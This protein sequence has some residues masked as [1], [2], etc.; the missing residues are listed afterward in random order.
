M[1]QLHCPLAGRDHKYESEDNENAYENDVDEGGCGLLVCE[2]GGD[3]Q[4]RV[5]RHTGIRLCVLCVS[6]LI[7]KGGLHC[8]EWVREGEI[9]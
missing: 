9:A 6:D 8:V 1:L 4:Q 2:V 7:G 3:A 5:Q